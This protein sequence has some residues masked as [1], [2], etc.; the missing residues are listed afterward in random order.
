MFP[1]EQLWKCIFKTNEL[2][3]KKKKNNKILGMRI[4]Q[5]NIYII[6]F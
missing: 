3:V 5:I 6:Y 2:L 4:K 1:M